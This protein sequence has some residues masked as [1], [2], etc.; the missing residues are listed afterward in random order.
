[1]RE[2]EKVRRELAER[3]RKNEQLRTAIDKLNERMQ[4][5]EI[6]KSA[7]GE[8]SK[9]NKMQDELKRKEQEQEVNKLKTKLNIIE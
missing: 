7:Q 8:D 3:D 6:Q 4:H 9:I 2:L 1:M 5:Y